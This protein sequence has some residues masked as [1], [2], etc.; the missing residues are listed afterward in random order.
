MRNGIGYR[1][2]LYLYGCAWPCRACLDKG[3]WSR[4]S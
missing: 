3:R 2:V 1:F 4:K